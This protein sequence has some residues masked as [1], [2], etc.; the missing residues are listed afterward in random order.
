MVEVLSRITSLLEGKNWDSILSMNDSSIDLI[1]TAGFIFEKTPIFTVV[2]ILISILLY[3][4]LIIGTPVYQQEQL[5]LS[6]KIVAIVIALCSIITFFLIDIMTPEIL[7]H[8]NN[9]INDINKSKEIFAG[10]PIEYISYYKSYSKGN[11]SSLFYILLLPYTFGIIVANIVI[12]FVKRKNVKNIN[13]SFKIISNQNKDYFD[14][15]NDYNLKRY[16]Y[17]GGDKW[18]IARKDI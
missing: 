4:I 5:T 16:L 6:F 7:K 3:I 10:A 17:Y 18:K 14:C 15:N 9:T 2:T 12:D 8:V 1:V 11:I 13:E